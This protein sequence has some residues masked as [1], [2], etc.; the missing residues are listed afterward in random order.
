MIISII[1]AM[2]EQNG[3]A[4][5]GRMPW[6]L[7]TD[8]RRFKAL[9]LDHHLVL[10]RKTF[11]SIGKALAGRVNIVVTRQAG[12]AAPGCLVAASLKQALALAEQQGETEVFVIGGGQIFAQA[13]P[14]AQRIYLTRVHTDA[15]A[16]V[17]FPALAEGEW[18]EGE[19]AFYPAGARDDFAHTFSIF[20]RL[21]KPPIDV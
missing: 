13:L 10:G 17:F 19:A 15:Q 4:K 1:V 9:T 2:D 16:D 14:L 6:H 20:S 11:D 7:S 5:D 12:F 18:Q 21:T 8:L 3:I